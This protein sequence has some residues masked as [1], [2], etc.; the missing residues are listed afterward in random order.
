MNDPSFFGY[1]SLVNLGTHDYANPRP[2]TLPGWRRV[3]RQTSLREIPYLSVER[4]PGA[5]IDGLVADVPGADWAALDI[6]ETGYDRIDISQQLGG[7]TAVYQVPPRNYGPET[8]AF[9]ILMSY[10]DIVV[11]G[12]LQIY[13]EAAVARFFE[14]TE[15]WNRPILNDREKPA[16]PRYH[17]L[18]KAEMDLVDHH[19][20]G[21]SAQV[22]KPV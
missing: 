11:Q 12:F 18:S 20:A 19:L 21:L 15:G 6:R 10:L 5:E 16:Y 2:A 4:A 17:H 3:W 8:P 9:P 14:T 1:G 7:Q 13:D 22:Q